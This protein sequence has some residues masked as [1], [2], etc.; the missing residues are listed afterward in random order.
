VATDENAGAA[1]GDGA[2]VGDAAAGCGAGE[3][4]NGADDNAG[5]RGDERSVVGDAAGEGRHIEDM[6]VVVTGRD[7]AG[8]ANAAAERL[9]SIV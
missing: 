5:C 8:V 7:R 3:D 2:A 9:R 1:G 4:A 6:N